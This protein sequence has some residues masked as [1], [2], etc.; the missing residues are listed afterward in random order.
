[1]KVIHI[2][3]T[4]QTKGLTSQ[5]TSSLRVGSLGWFT[6]NLASEAIRRSLCAKENGVEENDR[7]HFSSPLV[8]NGGSAAEPYNQVSPLTR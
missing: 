6:H 7:S 4:S 8:V 2:I 5:G 1:M 3:T